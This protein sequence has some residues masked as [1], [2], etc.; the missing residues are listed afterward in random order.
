MGKA[1][2]GQGMAYFP[3]IVFFAGLILAAGYGATAFIE[4]PRNV[5]FP[6]KVLS[7][8][9]LAAWAWLSGG[10]WLLTGALFASSIGDGF[11]AQKDGE[12]WLLPG[13]AAFFIAHVAYVILFNQHLPEG[14]VTNEPPQIALLVIAAVYL[15]LIS[16]KLG[17]MRWPVFA[18]AVVILAMGCAALTLPAQYVWAAY[19]AIAFIASDMILSLELFVLPEN[20]PARKITSP[21]VWVLYWGGQAAIA[22]AFISPLTV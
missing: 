1:C 4:D 11:L 2:L 7:V 20:A 5:R 12:K 18:Y 3:Q 16:S 15:G 9:A 21:L 19:G 17:A 6:V 14:I 8:W 13:M 22:Y 10:S